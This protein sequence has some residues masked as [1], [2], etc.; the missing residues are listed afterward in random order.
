MEQHVS[1]AIF[2][3]LVGKIWEKNSIYIILTKERKCLVGV[4]S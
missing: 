4:T 1:M 3:C 2:H